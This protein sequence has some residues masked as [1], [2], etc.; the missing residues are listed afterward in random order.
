MEVVGTGTPRGRRLSKPAGMLHCQWANRIAITAINSDFPILKLL[1]CSRTPQPSYTMW[2][3][4]WSLHRSTPTRSTATTLPFA[5]AT[6]AQR[7]NSAPVVGEVLVHRG[8]H[9]LHQQQQL[10]SCGWLPASCA[11]SCTCRCTFSPGV[12]QQQQ[13]QKQ[14]QNQNRAGSNA[15]HTLVL[16]AAGATT[17]HDA[18]AADSQMQQQQQTTTLDSTPARPAPSHLLPALLPHFAPR[19]GPV[20]HLTHFL[21]QV[22]LCCAPGHAY[23]VEL[24]TWSMQ[25][26]NYQHAIGQSMFAWSD[27]CC[28]HMVGCWL[29]QPVVM[30]SSAQRPA[31][32]N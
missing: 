29:L 8:H 12:M 5:A 32:G 17:P 18:A 10:L 20:A 4:W 1:F 19:E 26:L 21:R 27:S 15:C 9:L 25:S 14:K 23:S 7:L 2:V 11:R 22:G 24:P 30:P 3:L 31:Q 16:A 6:A 13:Q 28:R